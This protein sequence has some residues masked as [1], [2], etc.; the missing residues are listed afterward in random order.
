MNESALCYR[1][2]SAYLSVCLDVTKCIVT[3][4][5]MLQTSPLAQ[6]Y[7]LTIYIDLPKSG[8]LAADGHF[9]FLETII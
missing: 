3:K 4:L 7:L 1:R 2:M 6:I 8:I 5:Q 9:E